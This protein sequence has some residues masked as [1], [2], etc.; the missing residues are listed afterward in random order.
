MKPSTR[1]LRGSEG[2]EANVM[3]SGVN[4]RWPT[5]EEGGQ[6][7][8]HSTAM[9]IYN[10]GTFWRLVVWTFGTENTLSGMQTKRRPNGTPS[11][12]KRRLF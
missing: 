3:K 9:R 6:R 10:R 12:Q 5:D 2:G 11:A 8:R 4:V 1:N 7:S